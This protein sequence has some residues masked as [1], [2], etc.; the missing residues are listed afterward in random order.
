MNKQSILDFMTKR[1]TELQVQ[2]DRDIG[3]GL[4]DRLAKWQEC[5]YWKEAIERGQFDEV[6]K[7]G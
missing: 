7:D 6:D 4:T 5:K 1:M 2:I 3:G